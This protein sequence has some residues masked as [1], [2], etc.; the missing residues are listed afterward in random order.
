MCTYEDKYTLQESEKLCIQ[1]LHTVSRYVLCFV[2]NSEFETKFVVM[3]VIKWQ[4]IYTFLFK[5]VV[6]AIQPYSSDIC[7]TLTNERFKTIEWKIQYDAI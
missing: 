4:T 2:L 1:C 3:H 7:Y 5:Y 6:Q